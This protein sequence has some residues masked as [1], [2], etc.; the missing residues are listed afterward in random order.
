MDANL[1]ERRSRDFYDALGAEGLARRTS[2]EWDEAIVRDTAALLPADGRVL[3]LGCGDGRVTLPLA[4]RGF[5]IVG[6]DL[7]ERLI[8]AARDEAGRQNVRIPYVV[9]SMLRLPFDREAFVALIC[10]WSAF[11]ELVTRDE[12]LLAIG[13]M[14][15]VLAAGEFA[16]IEGPVFEEASDDE[17]REGTR[18]GPDHR[19]AGGLI[20]GIWNA[21]YRYDADSLG[22]LMDALGIERYTC[23]EREWAGRTRLF[24]RLER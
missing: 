22:R 24:L 21:N 6:L 10:L 18:F 16:L 13:E 14:R 17:I 5:A 1:S 4:R 15:R 9:G 12:Q 23:F 8:G 2:P 7:S 11:H 20:E 3:D 19:I